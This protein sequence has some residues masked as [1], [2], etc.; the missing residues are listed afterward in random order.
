MC[1]E[2][3]Q[4]HSLCFDELS[5]HLQSFPIETKSNNDINLAFTVMIAYNMVLQTTWSH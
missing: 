5:T 4:Y 2:G 1:I 3:I